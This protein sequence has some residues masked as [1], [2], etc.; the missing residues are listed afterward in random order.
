V[1]EPFSLEVRVTY[2]RSVGLLASWQRS[3]QH[4]NA[5]GFPIALDFHFFIFLC[6]FLHLAFSWLLFLGIFI[7]YT[8]FRYGVK[9]GNFQQSIALHAPTSNP[10]PIPLSKIKAFGRESDFRNGCLNPSSDTR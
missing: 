8:T 7:L 3:N 9:K 2:Y 4:K 6:L 5:D 1:A 10:T